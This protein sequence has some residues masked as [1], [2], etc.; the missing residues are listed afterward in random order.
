MLVEAKHILSSE[1]LEEYIPLN[2]PVP[3]CL[4]WRNKRNMQAM[5]SYIGFQHMPMHIW[6]LVYHLKIE[7]EIDGI[8]F[9]L[10]R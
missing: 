8:I 1:Q 4:N 9:H 7:P 2:I 6:L 10:T 3:W 5:L